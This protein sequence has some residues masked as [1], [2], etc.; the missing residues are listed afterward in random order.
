MQAETGQCNQCYDVEHES[1]AGALSL[2]D[3]VQLLDKV[4]P[5]FFG[6]ACSGSGSD[7]DSGSSVGQP[8][9]N[10][11]TSPIFMMQ[12]QQQHVFLTTHNQQ[13]IHSFT[14]SLHYPCRM[15]AAVT[16]MPASTRHAS[17]PN[18]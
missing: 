1:T 11:Q 6:H 8:S 16:P 5:V 15:H 18:A 2:H 4:L 13:V 7:T 12:Q 10:A 3:C 14:L 9:R 17:A